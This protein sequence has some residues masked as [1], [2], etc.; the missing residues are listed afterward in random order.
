MPSNT[1]KYRLSGM[2]TTTGT[3]ILTS[4]IMTKPAKMLPNSRIQS[5]SGRMPISMMLSGVTTATGSLNFFRPPRK[6]W[7][8]NCAP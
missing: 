5:D 4:S 2:G 7:T 1:S 6:P 8:R 3:A